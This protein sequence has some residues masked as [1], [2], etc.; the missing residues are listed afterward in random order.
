MS[1]VN[2]DEITNAS[3]VIEKKQSVPEDVGANWCYYYGNQYE[4]FSKYYKSHVPFLYHYLE[5]IQ[6]TAYYTMEIFVNH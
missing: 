4:G 3:M 1:E 2:T 5:H 6:T